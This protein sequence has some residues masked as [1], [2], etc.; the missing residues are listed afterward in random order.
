MATKIR[1]NVHT[2]NKYSVFDSD[3]SEEESGK[4][5]LKESAKNEI[6]DT[7]GGRINNNSHEKKRASEIKDNNSSPVI[8][9]YNSKK[10]LNPYNDRYNKYPITSINDLNESSYNRGYC[11]NFHV[12]GNNIRN[13]FSR[14]RGGYSNA[15]ANILGNNNFYRGSRNYDYKM[16][17]DRR[18]YNSSYNYNK[19]DYGVKM[20]NDY[21]DSSGRYDSMKRENYLDL[22]NKNYEENTNVLRKHES[23]TI[24]YDMY[25]RQQEK[26]LNSNKS[27][28]SVDKKKKKN[29]VNNEKS[30]KTT[31][32]VTKRNDNLEEENKSEHPKRKAIN[33]YQYILEEGGRVDRIPGFRRSF[34]SFKKTDDANWHN[35]YENKTKMQFDEKIF[36]KRDPP[37]INDTRAFPSL[38]S[39]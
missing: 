12:R 29:E 7:Y 18:N 10:P 34:R 2:T 8:K 32:T 11:D 25:R 21:N 26:K 36:K 27:I 6:N 17:M 31:G 4:A 19:F 22:K 24:D 35:K 9:E 23:V 30:N 14:K 5:K 16:N 33:V 3:N 39:K 28:E 15:S 13:K 1:Y 37:N 20:F 38:T